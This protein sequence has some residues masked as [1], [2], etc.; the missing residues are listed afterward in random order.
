MQKVMQGK[1]LQR[2]WSSPR[3]SAH[4]EIVVPREA[5]WTAV[6]LYRFSNWTANC[7]NLI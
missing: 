6:A 2:S 1:K 5:F 4:L 3:R 7:A